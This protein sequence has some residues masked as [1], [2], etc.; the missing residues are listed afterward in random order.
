ILIIRHWS[1]I[2]TS[3]YKSADK[4]SRSP[5]RASQSVWAVL[6]LPS[7]VPLSCSQVTKLVPSGAS[8][9]MVTYRGGRCLNV[10]SNF[11]VLRSQ[12]RTSPS[13]SHRNTRFPLCSTRS[14]LLFPRETYIVRQSGDS[15]RYP[16]L[17]R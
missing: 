14:S 9:I 2:S 4:S 11:P 3:Y 13:H 12:A 17:L 5:V 15:S 7:Y 1:D 6:A 8:R 16:Q 10:F